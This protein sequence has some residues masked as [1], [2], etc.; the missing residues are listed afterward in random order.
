MIRRDDPVE[1]FFRDVPLD[2]W[3][4][5]PGGLS[6][7]GTDFRALARIVLYFSLIS[8][9]LDVGKAMCDERATPDYALCPQAGIGLELAT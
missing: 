9:W 3:Q 8:C 1:N 7:R 4:P 6:S 2:G 5:L